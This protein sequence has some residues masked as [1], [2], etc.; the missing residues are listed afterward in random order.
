[1]DLSFRL[2]LE[3]V[4]SGWLCSAMLVAVILQA[5]SRPSPGFAAPLAEPSDGGYRFGA[6]APLTVT[7]LVAA[8][9]VPE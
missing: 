7:G 8:D 2:V 3:L 9:T 4:L 1:M 5:A 6:A